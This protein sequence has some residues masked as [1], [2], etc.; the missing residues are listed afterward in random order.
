[1]G[2]QHDDVEENNDK[3]TTNKEILDK[4]GDWGGKAYESGSGHNEG[5]SSAPVVAGSGYGASNDDTN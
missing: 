5:C 1:M 3:T 4:Q 2:G